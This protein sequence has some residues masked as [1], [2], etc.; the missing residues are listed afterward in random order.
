MHSFLWFGSYREIICKYIWKHTFLDDNNL[1]YLSSYTKIAA[2]IYFVYSSNF[3]CTKIFFLHFPNNYMMDYRT[4]SFVSWETSV[5]S[6]GSSCVAAC[7]GSLG[8]TSFFWWMAASLQIRVDKIP[9]K[10]TFNSEFAKW[11]SRVSFCLSNTISPYLPL[12]HQNCIL[13]APLTTD[14]VV[15]D[16]HHL[17]RMTRLF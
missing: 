17:N 12:V 7:Q 15:S 16:L 6:C 4:V 3:I 13:S 10:I 11:H 5:V 14:T 1:N 9:H 8:T 2:G